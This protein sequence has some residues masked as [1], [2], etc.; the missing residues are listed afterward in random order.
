MF[1]VISQEQPSIKTHEFTESNKYFYSFPY[2]KAYLAVTSSCQWADFLV[3][4]L[5]D[6]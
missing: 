3:N 4:L 5:T 2:G 1:G 6:R